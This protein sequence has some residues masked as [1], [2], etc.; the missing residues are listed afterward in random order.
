MSLRGLVV[1]PT[2]SGKSTI[3]RALVGRVAMADPELIQGLVVVD[4]GTEWSDMTDTVLVVTEQDATRE[5]DLTGYL[6]DHTRVLVDLS[7]VLDPAS[8]LGSLGRAILAVGNRLVVVDEAQHFL[9]ASRVAR[10]FLRLA[11]EG[12]K[13]GVSIVGI[14]QT[15]GLTAGAGLSPLFL[16]NLN[17][18]V[19]VGGQQEPKELERLRALSGR[20]DIQIDGLRP[21]LDGQPPEYAV[22]DLARGQGGIM[23]ASGWET[24]MHQPWGV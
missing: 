11:S 16:R 23:R 22:Y 2:G 7:G 24:P 13:R 14:T 15:L 8:F 1:G 6:R 10:D 12:R 3:A 9:P 5:W 4:Q 21:A 17:A 20:T 19:I 18:L